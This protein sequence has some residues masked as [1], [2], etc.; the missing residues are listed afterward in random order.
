MGKRNRYHDHIDPEYQRWGRIYP[1]FPG[2][3]EC[4]R[5]VR[6]GKARG[7]WADIVAYEL[8]QNAA[9]CLT[10]IIEAFRTNSSESVRLH[11]MMALDIA[12]LP[13][14]VSFLVE[15][16]QMGNPLFTP[17]AWRALNRID[18]DD[19]RAASSQMAGVPIRQLER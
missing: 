6:I 8:A 7:T 9:E 13:E 4:A 15:V 3:A 16:L 14:S 5:L 11:M 19:A 1:R 12:R 2:I 17:Y 10:E 18:S